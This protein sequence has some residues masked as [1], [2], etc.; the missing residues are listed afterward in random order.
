MI[1]FSSQ[2]I[3]FK[4]TNFDILIDDGPHTFDTVVKFIELYLPLLSKNGIFIIE[5]IQDW[6]WIDNLIQIVPDHYKQYIKVAD[7]RNIKNR[8]DDILFIIDLSDNI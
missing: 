1:L 3:F 6:S 4:S 8:Y 7:L 5:D 2:N